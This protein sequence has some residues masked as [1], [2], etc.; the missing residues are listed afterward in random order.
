MTTTDLSTMNLEEILASVKQDQAN[1]VPRSNQ[2]AAP[3][4]PTKPIWG[5]QMDWLSLA[6]IVL[7][8]V[9]YLRKQVRWMTLDFWMTST[10]KA[11]ESGSSEEQSL[12]D[13]ENKKTTL[14][15]RKKGKK[16][17]NQL[18][19][20]E[21]KVAESKPV[22]KTA[23]EGINFYDLAKFYAVVTMIIDHY[24]YFGLPGISY[25][26]AR[27]TRVIG[28][29]SAPMFFFLTGF[30]GSFRFRWQTWCY[31]VFMFV[32]NAWLN[33]R[34]TATSWES[35]VMCL[36][37]NWLFQYINVDKI[38]KWYWHVLIFVPLMLLEP[39]FSDVLRIAYGTLPYMLAI[40]GYLIKKNHYMGKWWVIATMVQHTYCAVGTFG[41][42]PLQT[43]WICILCAIEALVMAFVFKKY[44]NAKVYSWS[45]HVP[46]PLRDGFLYIS[47]NALIVYVVHLQLFRLI[48]MKVWNW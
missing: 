11:R 20:R 4:E 37:V 15:N 6:L 13:G 3:V 41:R 38:Q 12:L 27:W 22:K 46:K 24:G 26:M 16:S 39:Y 21:D 33:L 14:R 44:A 10:K 35:L 28:R 45:K 7:V 18:K 1:Y 5:N 17:K 2:K 25:T 9:D 31:A 40:A 42:T 34:L 30:S 8:F 43:Q 32:A 19:K 36:S 47:R 48:Q 23:P 29:T